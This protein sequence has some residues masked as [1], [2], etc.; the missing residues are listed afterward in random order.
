MV[1]VVGWAGR[2]AGA[3]L[4]FQ[5]MQQQGCGVQEVD[6]RGPLWVGALLLLQGG[7][8]VRGGRQPIARRALYERG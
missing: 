4:A 1:V 7:G 3:G 6:A 2:V 5:G 8:A